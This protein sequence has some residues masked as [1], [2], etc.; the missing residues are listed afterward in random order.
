MAFTMHPLTVLDDSPTYTA[1][2][3]RHVVNPFLFPSNST[4]FDCVQGVREGSPWPVVSISDLTVT[5]LPHCG[6][7]CPWVNVGAYTYAIKKKEYVNIPDSTG[8]YKVAIVVDDP[9]QSHGSRPRGFVK[10][11]PAGTADSDIPGLVL[12]YVNGGVVDNVAPRIHADGTVEV[13][14][15]DWLNSIPMVAGAEAVTSVDGRRYRRYGGQ[16]VPLTDIKLTP[17]LWYKD[18]NVYYT[19]SMSGRVVSISL[20]VSRKSEWVARAWDRSQIFVFPDYLKPT[21]NDINVPAAGVEYTG[22]QLD[23]SGLYVRPFRDI[24]YTTSGWNTASFSYP[25]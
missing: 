8:S 4:P 17:G 3:F 13:N 18:W 11:Y 20:S 6:V 7:V 24:T 10:V 14:N 2:D 9:S 25:V 22:F 1:D 23:P 19:C 5:V 12:A 16:W 21:L 15:S